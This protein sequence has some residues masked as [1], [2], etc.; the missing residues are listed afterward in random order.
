MTRL[1][2]KARESA[3]LPSTRVLSL[4]PLL[5][6]ALVGASPVY[7]TAEPGLLLVPP[8]SSSSSPPSPYRLGPVTKDPANPLFGEGGSKNGMP[9]ELAWWNTYP[10]VAYDPTDGLFKAWYNSWVNCSSRTAGFCPNKNY[11]KGH[12]FKGRVGATLYAESHDRVNWTKPNL[13]IVAWN[14]SKNNNIVFTT[15]SLDPNRGVLLDHHATDPAERFKAFGSFP[16]VRGTVGVATSKD[17][18]H[19]DGERK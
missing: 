11:P 12:E 5:A 4:L 9:W 8:S 14:G 18:I 19:W 13:G 2:S 7:L 1:L 17:G 15:G 6:L 10:T 3:I 16:T